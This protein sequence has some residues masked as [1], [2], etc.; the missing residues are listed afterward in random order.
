MQH[1]LIIEDEPTLRDTLAATLSSHGYRV[2]TSD[3][4]DLLVDQVNDGRPDLVV[5]DVMLP[6]IDGMSAC[7]AL[8]TAGS[9]I[10]VLMLTARSGDLDK[11][12]GLESG[13]DDYVTKPFSTGEL[14]A[15]VRALLRRAPALRQTV[16][17][18]GDLRIDLIGRRVSRGGAE[19]QLTHKEFNLL[20]ELVRNRGAVMSRDLLL[21]KVWGYDYFGDSRTVDVHIRWLR[22]KI[23]DD[24]SNP[25][26][27]TTLRGVGYRFDG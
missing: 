3:H 7:R 8:R 1:I 13:A 10:P 12:V 16:L 26:R 15:R 23:E 9:D 22:Q 4:A 25:A 19:I 2:A 27:I 17:E 11:I 20:A 14:V 24:P 6:G 21:E 5:L 18:S